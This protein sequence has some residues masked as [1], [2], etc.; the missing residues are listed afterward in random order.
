MCV[1][2]SRPTTEPDSTK[3]ASG[4]AGADAGADVLIRA[5]ISPTCT[6]CPFTMGHLHHH[7][8][9]GGGHLGHHL[10]RFHDCQ[11]LTGFY[12]LPG[13]DLQLDYGSFGE[14]LTDIGKMEL[15]QSLLHGSYAIT[16]RASA[17]TCS[18]L[19]R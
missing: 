16:F 13:G 11:G 15:E 10:V 2:S 1:V 17:I 14:T 8:L 12:M 19:M 4:V 18:A 5:T 6:T 7:A 3:G 9:D